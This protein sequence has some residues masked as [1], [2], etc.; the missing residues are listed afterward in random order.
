MDLSPIISKATVAS[1]GETGS[2]RN[3]RPAVLLICVQNVGTAYSTV[4]K[5]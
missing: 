2:W 3:Y 1:A 5:V 4:L